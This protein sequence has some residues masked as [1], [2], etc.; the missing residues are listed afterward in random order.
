MLELMRLKICHFSSAT[1]KLCLWE[2]KKLTAHTASDT[3]KLSA[4]MQTLPSLLRFQASQRTYERALMN[5][6]PVRKLTDLRVVQESCESI[7]QLQF[8]G[9]PDTAINQ[10][11]CTD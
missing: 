1:R 8:E 4:A 10:M 9:I 5:F 3:S 7:N 6:R 2:R 11:K